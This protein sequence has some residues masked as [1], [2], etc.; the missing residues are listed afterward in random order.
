M[1]APL[2]GIWAAA[3]TPIDDDLAPDADRAVAYYEDLLRDGCDGVALLGTTG[4]AMSLSAGQRLA[5]MEGVARRGL[6]MERAIVGTGAANLDDAVRLTRAAFDLGFAAALVMPP[7]FFRDAGDDGIVRYFDRLFAQAPPPEGRVVLYHF[8][9]MSGISFHAALV[10]RLVDE[11]PEAIVGLKDSSNDRA[12]QSAVIA[13]HPDLA[14]FPGSE[15][16]LLEAKRAGAAGCISGSVC[17]WPQLAREVWYGELPDAAQRC[18]AEERAKLDGLPLIAAVRCL[19]AR[20]RDDEAW[21]V[22]IP[23]LLPL[24]AA[25]AA[26][27]RASGDGID[28]GT[29]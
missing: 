25:T 6:P 24:D 18:M 3:L 27:L 4:E 19:T 28:D 10:D 22:P 23:P 16:Y 29:A 13:R 2:A 17:L 12:L 5:F 20:V 26:A 21:A 9:R 11:F 8:P 7:F 1:S 14:V 15:S